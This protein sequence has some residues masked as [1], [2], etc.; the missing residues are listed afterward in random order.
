L[1]GST[2]WSTCPTDPLSRRGFAD[3]AGPA[4]STGD[5]DLESQ[6]E[7][8]SLLGRDAPVPERLATV[9]AK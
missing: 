7:L 5:A 8:F 2:R 9:R 4:A 3:G 6:Q 1:I